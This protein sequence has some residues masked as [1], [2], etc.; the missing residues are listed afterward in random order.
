MAA[1]AAAS[2]AAVVAAAGAA[3]A[4]AGAAVAATV[5]RAAVVSAA[6][7]AAASLAVVVALGVLMVSLTGA[8]LATGG[9][10]GVVVRARGL[11][12]RDPRRCRAGR[13][14]EGQRVVA[15]GQRRDRAPDEDSGRGG[16]EEQSAHG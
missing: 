1:V 13:A 2:V 9:D 14:R 12:G 6:V 10:R 11:G 7:V 16:G 15:D 5:V 3:V 4:A 8:V